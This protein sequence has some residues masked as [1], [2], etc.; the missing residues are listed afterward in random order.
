[1]PR[2]LNM[3]LD[4]D[5]DAILKARMKAW[6]MNQSALVRY[7]LRTMTIAPN[8]YAAPLPRFLAHL[9]ALGS[10][11]ERHEEIIAVK[12]GWCMHCGGPNDGPRGCQC[13]NDE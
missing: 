6:G 12:D 1:M 2:N 7:A 9:K 11:N 3:I 4:D 8:T 10:D 13:W 5:T